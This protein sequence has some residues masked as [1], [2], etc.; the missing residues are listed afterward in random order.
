MRFDYKTTI[1]RLNYVKVSGDSMWCSQFTVILLASY[2]LLGCDLRIAIL[3]FELLGPVL[4]DKLSVHA[5]VNGLVPAP[6]QHLTNCC[7]EALVK[8]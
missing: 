1:F 3:I 8:P 7:L 2:F 6:S 5:V 4:T